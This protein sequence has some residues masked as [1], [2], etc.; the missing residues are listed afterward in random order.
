[1]EN[2]YL[3]KMSA[4]VYGAYADSLEKSIARDAAL[5]NPAYELDLKRRVTELN[6]ITRAYDAANPG[7][8][9]QAKLAKEQA[10]EARRQAL[11]AKAQATPVQAQATQAASAKPSAVPTSTPLAQ[12]AHSTSFIRKH[13][14]AVG[15]AG[16]AGAGLA[17]YYLYKRN[18]I[19]NMENKYLNKVATHIPMRDGESFE[20]YNKRLNSIIEDP[21]T[22]PTMMADLD[23][24]MTGKRPEGVPRIT[25]LDSWK[26]MHPDLK[27]ILLNALT[28]E[29]E[30]V[31]NKAVSTHAPVKAPVQAQAPVQPKVQAPVA[32]VNVPKPSPSLAERALNFAKKPAVATGL[33]GA[34]GLAGAAGYHYTKQR[35]GKEN[36]VGN[37]YLEKAAK[38]FEE[39][40]G[41]YG[42]GDALG[43]NMNSAG[44]GIFQGAATAATGIALHELFPTRHGR[45]ANAGIAL[46]VPAGIHGMLYSR[47]NSMN[48]AYA[49]GHMEGRYVPD[50]M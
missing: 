14:L 4:S 16:L 10:R 13:P 7:H 39:D 32:P 5:N 38:L 46:A 43:S 33:I 31:E 40:K 11:Q 22:K 28:D 29:G 45:I 35:N 2:K 3:E 24:F 25:Q 34:A 12:S 6:D 27:K 23:E 18:E 15:S 37:K 8:K 41:P 48:E 36:K 49:R 1:M 30:T 26:D 20:S 19:K 17:G 44:R 50:G 47:K 21:V 42:Y 9:E